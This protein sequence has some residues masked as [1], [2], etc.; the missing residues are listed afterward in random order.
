M[1]KDEIQTTV[2]LTAKLHYR[3]ADRQGITLGP[4]ESSTTAERRQFRHELADVIRKAKE[5][6]EKAVGRLEAA[7]GAL[8]T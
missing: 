2:P 5:M 6:G 8:H 1:V 7:L 4:N 3:R